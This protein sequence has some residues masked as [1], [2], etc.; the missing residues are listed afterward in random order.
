VS[1]QQAFPSQTS[2]KAP[3]YWEGDLG[4]VFWGCSSARRSMTW[5]WKPST[6]CCKRLLDTQ[7]ERFLVDWGRE[8]SQTSSSASE[9]SDIKIW[10]NPKIQQVIL[11]S[12]ILKP[13]QK[14]AL[15]TQGERDCH[16]A[17]FMS[18]VDQIVREIHHSGMLQLPLRHGKCGGRTEDRRRVSKIPGRGPPLHIQ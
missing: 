12:A 4:V 17:C 8:L 16:P 3:I 14:L 10:K 5:T 11:L 2:S 1:R 6:C 9:T 18:D 15:W 13:K 7:F